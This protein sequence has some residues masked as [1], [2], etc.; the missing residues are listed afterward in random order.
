MRVGVLVLDAVDDHPRRAAAAPC[1]S[2]GF[3]LK[4]RIVVL[5]S[6]WICLCASAAAPAAIASIAMTDATPSTMPRTVERGP[7]RLVQRG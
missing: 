7:E 5:P 6:A 3:L 2:G 4:M 1:S